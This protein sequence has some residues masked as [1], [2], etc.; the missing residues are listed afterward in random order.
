MTNKHEQ[1]RRWI[2]WVEAQAEADR[3]ERSWG[4]TS[5][6]NAKEAQARADAAMRFWMAASF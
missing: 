6:H 5:P 4:V 3:A 1:V 2:V